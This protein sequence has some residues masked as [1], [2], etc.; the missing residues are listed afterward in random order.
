MLASA[1]SLLDVTADRSLKA[2]LRQSPRCGD[3]VELAD[4][5]NAMA[6]T[7]SLPRHH[8]LQRQPAKSWPTWSPDARKVS[9]P[10]AVARI[11]SIA[12]RTQ[13]LLSGATSQ[14]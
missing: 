12:G 9:S 6:P 3:P 13:I 14:R 10:L 5:Y 1:S 2:S 8:R 7:S 11:R 4:R